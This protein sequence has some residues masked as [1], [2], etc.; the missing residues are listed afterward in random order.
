MSFSP[1]EIFCLQMHNCHIL[2]GTFTNM[3]PEPLQSNNVGTSLFW[4]SSALWWPI[5]NECGFIK[6]FDARFYL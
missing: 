3:M 5:N 6:W 2:S 1:N 4:G